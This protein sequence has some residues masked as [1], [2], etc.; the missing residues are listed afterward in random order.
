MFLSYRPRHRRRSV[1]VLPRLAAAVTLAGSL[2]AV[3]LATGSAHAGIN[4]PP[5]ISFPCS[6]CIQVE[7]SVTDALTSAISAAVPCAQAAVNAIR[8]DT[9]PQDGPDSLGCGPIA[10]EAVSIVQSAEAFVQDCEN[11]T[12]NTCQSAKDTLALALDAASGCYDAVT[13]QFAPGTL[14]GLASTDP[15]NCSGAVT[16][17]GDIVTSLAALVAQ[18]VSGGDSTCNTVLGAIAGVVVLIVGTANGCINDSTSPCAPVIAALMKSPC[19]DTAD[20]VGC[21][22]AI[23]QPPAAVVPDADPQLTFPTGVLGGSLQLGSGATVANIPVSFYVQPANSLS[24]ATGDSGSVDNLGQTVTDSN[25]NFSFTLPAL[26]AY[27]TSVANANNGVLN[28]IE[29]ATITAAIPNSPSTPSV[30]EAAQAAVPIEVGGAPDYWMSQPTV[31]TLQPVPDANISATI[32]APLPVQAQVY[33]PTD[34]SVDPSVNYQPTN[35]SLVTAGGLPV[36]AAHFDPWIV[37]GIDYKNAIP[38]NSAASVD[39]QPENCDQGDYMRSYKVIDQADKPVIVGEAHAYWDVTATFKYGATA[40]SG[41]Q[42][43]W[44]YDNETWGVGGSEDIENTNGAS[45]ISPSFGPDRGWQFTE[46]FHF[47]DTQLN[48]ECDSTKYG[49]TYWTAYEVEPTK[50]KFHLSAG[51]SVVRYDG[52]QPYYKSNTN[53]RDTVD[54][55][56]TD[57]LLH[58]KAYHYSAAFNAFGASFGAVSGHSTD[59]EQSITAG[60]GSDGKWLFHDIW[61]SNK[62]WSDAQIF[63]SY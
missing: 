10:A 7:T 5:G 52:S 43:G 51:K 1:G 21:A 18:C 28:V 56:V 33:D 23:G 59:V 24:D 9:S 3:P 35:A 6:V 27:A 34:S 60:H 29:V 62:Y 17:A 37:N 48:Y 14:P 58:G 39:G 50:C 25:G 40:D 36:S 44:G 45:N 16:T 55:G 63:Y 11:G 4:L 53:Y 26:D 38:V 42:V 47:T 12:V 31:L 46:I 13:G 32:S 54:N 19:S 49:R 8:P 2:L 22:E 61:G 57:T 20:P 30:F 41:I 15:V